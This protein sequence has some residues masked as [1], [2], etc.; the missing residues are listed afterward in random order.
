MTEKKTPPPSSKPA[1]EDALPSSSTPF[2]DSSLL[3]LDDP[4]IT[5]SLLESSSEPTPGSAASASEASPA[6]DGETS[7]AQLWAA[8]LTD[9]E[10]QQT[11]SAEP[12]HLST[13]DH[14]AVWQKAAERH[15]LPTAV[16][17]L[18]PVLPPSQED[19]E[20]EES[21]ASLPTGFF[22]P[23]EAP[24]FFVDEQWSPD[25]FIHGDHASENPFEE[26]VAVLNELSFQNT[27]TQEAHSESPLAP[28]GDTKPLFSS[29]PSQAIDVATFFPADSAAAFLSDSTALF[30][31]STET[32]P[33]GSTAAFPSDDSADTFPLDSATAFLSGSVAVFPSEGAE[34]SPSGSA[35]APSN[36]QSSPP[37]LQGNLWLMD[38]SGEGDTEI[39]LL[40]DEL[41]PG[42][43]D[44]EESLT[45]VDIYNLHAAPAK[46]FPPKIPPVA[47]AGP[48]SLLTPAIFHDAAE[49]PWPPSQKPH[50]PLSLQI[51][52]LYEVVL[53]TM[54]GT[55]KRG[56]FKDVD[57]NQPSVPLQ[58]YE[59]TEHISVQHI[60]AVYFLKPNKGP[61]HLPPATATRWKVVFNDGRCVEG[62][63]SKPQED[64][65]GFFLVPRQEKSP[66][67]CLYINRLA[68]PEISGLAN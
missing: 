5:G 51:Q 14:F 16:E 4:N 46:S 49:T 11:Y 23:D 44:E 55:V 38:D 66:T 50:A 40:E 7:F 45:Q 27:F 64:A 26:S 32:L 63:L 10:T 47:S 56:A 61:F 67:A 48:P 54:S 8:T 62:Q 41:P 68:V 58:T 25:A 42:E 19:E 52:G 20:E 57:L 28:T 2:G 31:E 3:D 22:S 6:E 35:V 29:V 30:P 21:S 24:L 1:T 12:Q 59:E 65:A 18:P 60:K 17:L 37:Q 9:D 34:T 33:S 36:T 43:D 13:E 15:H 53:Y 39:I